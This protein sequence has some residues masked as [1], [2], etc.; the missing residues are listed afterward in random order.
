VLFDAGRPR[1][2]LAPYQEALRLAPSATLVRG[3]LA[4]AM[5]ETGDPALLRPAV[6]QLQ[7]ALAAA[8]DQAEFWRAMSEAQ[9]KLGNTGQAQLAAAEAALTT[10]D[11][12]RAKGFA[13][14]ARKHL[15]AGPDRLRADDI[16]NAT[17][18]ENL[19]G[20]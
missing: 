14:E 4:R 2:A 9:G 18:K 19:E 3:A 10:G 20:F 7:I 11:I 12:A 1:E 16:S 5:I 15:P 13:I 17:K 6:T 8:P